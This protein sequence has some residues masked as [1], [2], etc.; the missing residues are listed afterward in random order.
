MFEWTL[1]VTTSPLSTVAGSSEERQGYKE[2]H[3]KE[4]GLAADRVKLVVFYHECFE[5]GTE[6][7]ICC[8]KTKGEGVQKGGGVKREG[9]RKGR[10][11]K[12]RGIKKGEVSNVCVSKG[13]VSKGVVSKGEV[14][15]GC[16]SKGWF[17]K[18]RGSKGRG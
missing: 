18:G 8:I 10:V 1:R 7:D 6:W 9:V 14:S 5:F 17:Q 3:W 13:E 15:K 16:I 4:R 2:V 12:G 11:Q